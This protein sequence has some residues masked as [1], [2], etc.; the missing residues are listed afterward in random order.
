MPGRAEVPRTKEIEGVRYALFDTTGRHRDYDPVLWRHR[1][2]K[3]HRRIGWEMWVRMDK[4]LCA[5]L[6]EAHERQVEETMD[7]LSDGL[8]RFYKSY[9]DGT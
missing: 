4:I 6:R 5:V 2:T 8:E 3:E 1:A 7:A 9:L